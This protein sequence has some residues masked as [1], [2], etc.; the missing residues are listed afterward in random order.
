MAV[1]TLSRKVLVLNQ[2]YEPL[3]I[4]SAKK[5]IVLI[6]SNKVEMIERKITQII[7]AITK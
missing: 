4:V 1:N 3:M 7:G 5:G 6:L 2:S